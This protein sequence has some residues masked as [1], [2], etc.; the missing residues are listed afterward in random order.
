VLLRCHT[1]GSHILFDAQPVSHIQNGS[2]GLNYR[3]AAADAC[4]DW[5]DVLQIWHNQS[6]FG[7]FTL[8]YNDYMA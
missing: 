1:A 8:F 6:H 2:N 5:Y 3:G 7:E 4:A